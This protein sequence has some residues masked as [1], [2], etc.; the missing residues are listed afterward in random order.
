MF[1]TIVKLKIASEKPFFAHCG[2]IIPAINRNLV[3]ICSIQSV[4]KIRVGKK[5]EYS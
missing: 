2:E 5:N 1:V 4:S 3:D